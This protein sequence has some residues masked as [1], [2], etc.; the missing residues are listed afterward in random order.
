MRATTGTLRGA[1][2]VVLPHAWTT[3][4][5][6]AE[7]PCAIW[8]G[9]PVVR[10][11]GG[12]PRFTGGAPGRL[13]KVRRFFVILGPVV[14]A[15]LTTA[16][17]AGGDEHVVRAGTVAAAAPAASIQGT[18]YRI[19]LPSG[20]LT[21]TV[22]DPVTE[23]AS[24]QSADHARLLA[25][26]GARLRGV[27]WTLD[28]AAGP[29]YLGNYA[30][31]MANEVASDVVGKSAP[32]SLRLVVDGQ[33]VPL[34]TKETDE[35][36]SEDS[37]GGGTSSPPGVW[38]AI[39]SGH[40][41]L[42]V[43][44]DGLVQR[45]D[46]ASGTV[47]RGAASS[48]SDP[49]PAAAEGSCESSRPWLNCYSIEAQAF[50]YVGGHGWARPGRTWLVVDLGTDPDDVSMSRVTVAGRRPVTQLDTIPTTWVYDVPT[51]S[52]RLRLGGV[53][54]ESGRTA[55]RISGWLPGVAR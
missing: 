29:A 51:G 7:I 27:Q 6:V 22:T 18:D 13:A 32:V 35:E 12:R 53:V 55:A 5:V 44:Y 42:E 9:A 46:L 34:S 25:P 4:G 20:R 21:V 14:L 28:P 3:E 23:V 45:V 36:E 8:G 50:P 52:D 11:A 39:P 48:L 40:A 30:L 54:A 31:F 33:R 17:G 37:G 41:T 47:D 24:R 2:G 19:M 16:C 15:L 10:R 49:Q 38:A 43:E 26:S 1:E